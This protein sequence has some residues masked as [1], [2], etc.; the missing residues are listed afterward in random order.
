[1]DEILAVGDAAFQKKCLGKMEDVARAGRTVLFVSHNMGAVRSLCTKGLV[2]DAGR[3]AESGDIERCIESY[4]KMIGAFGGSHEDP[5][6]PVSRGTSGFGRVRLSGA[7]P[8]P[9]LQS[10]PLEARTTLTIAQEVSG[11]SLFCIVEDMQNRMVFHLR[12]ESPSLGLPR[13]APGEYAIG[14]L[15]PPLWLNSGLYSLSFKVLLWGVSD[16]A[17]HLSDKFPL[18]V[19]GRHSRVDALLHPESTW[20]VRPL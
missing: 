13:V 19:T 18:D 16:N 6:A 7:R 1:V 5:E 9:V 10:D 4:F 12:E 8:G 15:L 14:V 20:T 3:L 11:F 2:L 17:R